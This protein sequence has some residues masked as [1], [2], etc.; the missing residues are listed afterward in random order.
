MLFNIHINAAQT[1]LSRQFSELSGFQLT[2]YSQRYDKFQLASNNSIQIH[3]T[4]AFHWAVSTSIRCP[5]S[6]RAQILDSMSGDLSSSMQCQLAKIYGVTG[7]SDTMRVE[8]SPV[9]QQAGST[10][11]GLFTIAFA[12]D[13]AFGMDP[14]KISYQQSAMREHFVKCLENEKMEQ[15]PQSKCSARTNILRGATIP[16]YC[17]CKMPESLD[18]MVE[19][20]KHVFSGSTIAV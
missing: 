14:V 8:I 12:T 3:H 7:K 5:K 6:C 4:D 9:Q 2:N 1:L 18:N 17:T 16:V 10:D 13:L 15:F 19:C 20:K 11:C